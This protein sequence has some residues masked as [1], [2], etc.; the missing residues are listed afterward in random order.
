MRS[1][2]AQVRWALATVVLF[3][4]ASLC[5]AATGDFDDNGYVDLQDFVQFDSCLTDSGPGAPPGAPGCLDAFD[6][7]TDNDVDL[8]DYASFQT[9]VGHLPVPLKDTLA[10]AITIT[11]TAPYSSRQTCG[12]CHDI[13]A[14]ANA[15]H[16]QQGRTDQN[17]N[18]VVQDDYYGDGRA[19]Q[20]SAGMYG[21][22]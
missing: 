17:G 21:K 8:R 1:H 9:A 13:N 4:A 22:W 5:F 20:R 6:F 19:F 7:D 12:G 10:N 11:S 16:F 15:Y 2:S 14:I 3:G 18:I